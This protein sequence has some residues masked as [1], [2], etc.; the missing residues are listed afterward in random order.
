MKNCHP[1]IGSNIKEYM[2][3]STGKGKI[4]GTVTIKN[5]TSYTSDEHKYEIEVEYPIWA[6]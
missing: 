3:R 2:I 5:P 6:C 4:T 1:V